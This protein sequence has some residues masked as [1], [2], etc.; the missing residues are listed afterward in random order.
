LSS[1]PPSVALTD[2]SSIRLGAL[3]LQT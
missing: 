2:D 1:A 3:D